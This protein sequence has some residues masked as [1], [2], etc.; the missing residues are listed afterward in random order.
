M[1]RFNAI[2]VCSLLALGI[3]WST[4]CGPA[5]WATDYV[6]G[7]GLTV[8]FQMPKPFKKSDDYVELQKN[9]KFFENG[10]TSEGDDEHKFQ[11]RMLEMHVAAS[12]NMNL[13]ARA[14][15][16]I[17]LS[18]ANQNSSDKILDR[19]DFTDPQW[20]ANVTPAEEL[21]IESAD[22][23]TIKHIRA[24]VYTGRENYICYVVLTAFRPRSESRS[25]DVD[26]FFNSLRISDN[27]GARTPT[28]S[29]Q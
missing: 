15:L 25:P 13:D 19:H 21:T 10:Y 16:D 26:K 14:L 11:F 18:R 24:V 3:A 22:G 5:E 7:H 2:G 6:P 23:K 9:R 4:S 8:Y 12:L 28:P 29:D 20:P 1:K 27:S 17:G